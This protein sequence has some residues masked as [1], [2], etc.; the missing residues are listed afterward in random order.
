MHS[1][2]AQL[3]TPHIPIVF[4]QMDEDRMDKNQGCSFPLKAALP[5]S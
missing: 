4:I 3:W 5:P 1:T 2:G